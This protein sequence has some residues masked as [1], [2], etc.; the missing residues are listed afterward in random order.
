MAD[1]MPYGDAVDA[2][3]RAEMRK[4]WSILHPAS[5]TLD[6]GRRIAYGGPFGI[7]ASGAGKTGDSGL[8]ATPAA[9]G[10]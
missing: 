10:S 3:V 8:V 4:L 2:R 9:A 1:R 7:Q 5:R 6:G